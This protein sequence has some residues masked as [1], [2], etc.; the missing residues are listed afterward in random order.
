MHATFYS[1]TVLLRFGRILWANTPPCSAPP[2]TYFQYTD[3]HNLRA[4]TQPY[5]TPPHMYFQDTCRHLRADTQ[6]YSTPPHTCFQDTN[7]ILRAN[8]LLPLLTPTPHLVLC[9]F[10]IFQCRPVENGCSEG[11]GQC[12]GSAWDGP[13]CCWPGA[14]CLERSEW[15]HQCVPEVK[16]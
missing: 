11:W 1:H 10:S 7:G 16:E 9:V 3:D 2:H 8:I 4:D 12:G 5:F 14:E 6:S 13:T 15:Y